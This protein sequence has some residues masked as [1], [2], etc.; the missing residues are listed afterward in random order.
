VAAAPTFWSQRST[1]AKEGKVSRNYFRASAVAVLCSG[2]V[3]VTQA[4][5]SN[6]AQQPQS[7]PTTQQKPAASQPSTTLAG[8]VYREQDVPGRSPNVAERAGI[9]EDY[10]LAEV[11]P[12]EPQS[13]PS[14]GTPGAAGTS[15]TVKSSSMYK[16]ELI[17]DDKLRAL[18]GKRVEV[19]GR[20]DAEPGDK[21]ATSAT[22]PTTP[23]DRAIG[24]DRIDLPEFEVT[25]IREVTG[26]CPAK[27]SVR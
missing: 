24:R 19:T 12:K 20:I 18:V 10:I 4:G 25:S 9:L 11:T 1:S 8:C 7:Q 21:A 5:T 23:T 16:L 14:S 15:G 27:P 13:T 2:A 3:V 26:T 6:Q 22:P 17:A